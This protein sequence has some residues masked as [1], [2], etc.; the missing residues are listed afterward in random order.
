MFKNYLKIAW[1]NLRK[2]KSYSLINIL[3]LSSG[4]ACA[5]LIF[6]VVSYQLSFDTFHP[7]TERLYRVVTEFHNESIEYQSG[8]PQPL[9]KAFRNDYSFM[10]TSA[11]VCS[12]N[13]A[14]LS[15]P[16][17]KETKKFQEEDGVAYAE[18][19]FF[20]LFNFPLVKGDHLHPLTEPNTALITQ[21]IAAK[22]FGSEEPIG[23]IIRYNNQTDFRITG[24][25]KDIPGNTDRKQEIYLSYANLKDLDPYLASD[26]SWGTVKSSMNFFIRL[27]PGVSAATVEAQLPAFNKKYAD[28]DDVKT[29]RFRLQP[30]NDIHFNA[31]Y[32]GQVNKSYLWVLS[33]IGVFLV[34]T[35]CVNFINLATAR[36]L[37]RAKE[38]GVRKV[39]GSL[40]PQLFWQFIF[41][42][43]LL[44]LFSFLL[45]SSLA[46]L[47]LP[48]LND[49][50]GTKMTIGLLSNPGTLGF[51]VLLMITII[52][53]AGSY[54]GLVL[55]RFKPIAALKG[56]LSQRHIGGFSLR[57]T[58][59][60]SQFAISQMLVIGMIVIAGQ[61]HY[62]KTTDLGFRKD[63]IVLLPLP[64]NDRT[65]M[66][67]LFSR[68]SAVT[69]TDNITLCSEA[70]ASRSR[71]LTT[72][73]YDSRPKDE[74]W[75]INI[76]Y[77]DAT[78]V[79][80]YGLTLVAGRNVFPSDTLRELLINETCVRKLHLH[81][82]NAIIGKRLYFS[83]SGGGYSAPVTGV[84]KDF[85]NNSFHAPI[86]PIVILPKASAYRFASAKINLADMHTIMPA[87][88]K[89]WNETYPDYVYSY[90][91]LD[92]RIERFYK[93]DTI[94]FRL[95]EW[96]AGIAILISCLGL[97]GLV[98]FLAVQKTKEIGVRKVL[99]AGVTNILWLF[100]REFSRLLL[101][102]FII[103]APIAGWAMH[104]WLQGFQ[105]RI[106]ISWEIFALAIGSTFCIALLTV[107]WHSVKAAL[108][109]PVKSLGS[110]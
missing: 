2:N 56:K 50:I 57:R 30:L 22:Y 38:V 1:R 64:Q 3:G 52:F 87:Y 78:Y 86:D 39:M 101:L 73:R 9:G 102:A 71:S 60:V 74:S 46:L 33:L 80:T 31:N 76:K 108:A 75:E 62:S 19:E 59:V 107:A 85:H 40:R 96:F 77:G 65:K 49:L 45:A 18:P 105:Y 61:I 53:L 88:E 106:S 37:N 91:F 103:A 43:A 98:A 110:E 12:F 21:R 82:P 8:V 35:A 32:D 16:G 20:D 95:V 90:Q 42:T 68:L 13:N 79:P 28:A 48:A 84:I 97:Y 17:E 100:G 10:E 36:A 67:T 104:R 63:G 92:E 99:G 93:Q 41:E 4:I 25:L 89:I 69:G 66:N 47:L 94:I 14:L 51:L 5:I 34:I 72:F 58:L 54:P 55:A 23:R 15:L 83:N 6:I 109:N 27:K 26:S 7:H 11:R 29:Q 24:I 81:D 44:V 70:P